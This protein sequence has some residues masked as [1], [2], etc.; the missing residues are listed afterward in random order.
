[1]RT[2]TAFVV[3][4]AASVSTSLATE[5][6]PQW[7]GSNRDGISRETGLLQQWPPGGPR[8]VW[9]A[10]GLGSGYSTVTIADGRIFTLGAERDAEYVIA[11]DVASGKELWR[12]RSGRRYRNGRGDGPRGAP[13]V[14]GNRVYALGGNGDLT[15]LDVV[16]GKHVWSIN[17]LEAF[18]GR[19]TSW[20]ISESPLVLKDRVIVNAGGV[21]ALPLSRSTRTTA[22]LC[23][24]AKGTK[25]LTPP[26]SWR[27]CAAFGKPFTSLV[28]GRSA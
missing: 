22:R 1:M 13:T 12:A 2:L 8:A 4:T 23:G 20:G 11:R 9:K 28:S 3:I 10:T 6:W 27:R 25:L 18:D 21:G 7:R 5:D 16:S 26:P 17:V 19:N 15:V 14:D 24:K